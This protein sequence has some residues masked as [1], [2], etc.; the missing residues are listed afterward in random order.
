MGE[1]LWFPAKRPLAASHF[2]GETR[3]PL[4]ARESAKP[5]AAAT[6]EETHDKHT[7]RT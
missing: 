4:L 2:V 6:R 1:E 7:D 3:R 5:Q